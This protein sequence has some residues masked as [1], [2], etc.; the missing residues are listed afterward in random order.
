MCKTCIYFSGWLIHHISPIPQNSVIGNRQP[1]L[2]KVW[3]DLV[4]KCA[5]C[6]HPW[7]K[8][9]VANLF[10]DVFRLNYPSGRGRAFVKYTQNCA[11]WTNHPKTDKPI[12][13][14]VNESI[15]QSINQWI[16]QPINQSINQSITQST[17]QS[18]NNSIHQTLNVNIIDCHHLRVVEATCL[19]SLN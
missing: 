1:L 17:N 2:A 4:G 18:M 14:S 6:M 15:N 16:N 8:R 11:K 5:G 9:G 13:P 12:N 19:E 3:T 10:E 7:V